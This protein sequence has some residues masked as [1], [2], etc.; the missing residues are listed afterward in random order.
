VKLDVISLENIKI[1]QLDLPDDIYN[2]AYREDIVA[3][4]VNWQLAKARSGNHQTKGLSEVSGSTKKPF[5]QKG[6]GRARQ[7]SIRSPQQRG[8]GIVFG[9]QTRDHSHKLPKKIRKL[10]LK[11]A[12]SEKIRQKKVLVVD[13]LKFE[14]SKTKDMIN[15][16]NKLD[17]TRPL[18]VDSHEFEFNFLNSSYNLCDVNLLKLEG[19]NVYDLIACDS[20]VLTRD[21]VAALNE[22]LR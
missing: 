4:V 13:N 12:V 20:V 15:V 9:P 7:G 6:T 8:G 10:G 16:L 3:R 1:D 14:S 5:R 19:L 22:R 18:F 21:A 2:I 17:L 11:I